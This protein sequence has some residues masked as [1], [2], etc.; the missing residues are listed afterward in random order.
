MMKLS[1]LLIVFSLLSSARARAAGV[2][3]SEEFRLTQPAIVPAPFWRNEVRLA[4][5][6]DR[7]LAT[8]VD[9]RDREAPSLRAMRLTADGAPIDPLGFPVALV[10]GLE[11]TPHAVASDGN[12]FLVAWSNF[13]SISLARISRDGEVQR[14]PGF[15]LPCQRLSLVFD[16]AR[17][18]LTASALR[19]PTPTTLVVLDRTGVALHAPATLFQAPL[20]ALATASASDGNL[21]LLIG[22]D[23]QL[24]G[25]RVDTKRLQQNQ[26]S[27]VIDDRIPSET[28][29]TSNGS[30]YVA[31][32]KSQSTAGLRAVKLDLEGKPTGPPIL[33]APDGSSPSIV[34]TGSQY[35]IAYRDASG[36]QS[37]RHDAEL[38]AIG[39][40]S[41]PV[42]TCSLCSGIDSASIAGNAAIAWSTRSTD[43][44]YPGIY[45]HGEV[46]LSLV[47]PDGT[48]GSAIL[49][50]GGH[51]FQESPS[52]IWTGSE[53]LFSWLEPKSPTSPTRLRVGGVSAAGAPLDG[54]GVAVADSWQAAIGGG[55]G[56]ALIAWTEL[57]GF[58]TQLKTAL[59]TRQ[60]GTLVVGRTSIIDS[61]YLGSIAVVWNGEDFVVFYVRGVPFLPA[62]PGEPAFYCVHVNGDGL[63][64][65]PIRLAGASMAELRGPWLRAIWTGTDYYAAFTFPARQPRYGFN[66]SEPVPPAEV[67]GVRIARNLFPE[68]PA[69]LGELHG[70]TPVLALSNGETVVVWTRWS[71]GVAPFRTDEGLRRVR[72]RN[73]QPVDPVNGSEIVAAFDV[74]LAMSCNGDRCTAY[75]ESKLWTFSSSGSTA[76]A[77]TSLPTTVLGVVTGGPAPLTVYQDAEG[78]LVGRYILPPRSRVVGRR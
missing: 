48:A 39:D 70:T 4:S 57:N 62:P 45:M 40:S 63:P 25:Q 52:G 2:L 35:V 34:W 49:A 61:G 33:V 51:P 20:T 44:P 76:A 53:F 6:G 28:D 73:G 47:R 65:K 37:R 31:V 60:Q 1:I 13:T 23:L 26:P 67:Y 74:P 38:R 66:P 68:A 71:D 11:T 32:W 27:H 56:V 54:A 8:W 10:A 77:S 64:G 55:N 36:L 3:P 69:L 46:R 24:R 22:G 19:D 18:L 75:A 78:L 15:A 5:A 7:L 72:I 30:E 41:S 17:F 29:V 42:A 12:D 16:G 43:R 50:S 59:L 14:L 21:L 58:E 9:W